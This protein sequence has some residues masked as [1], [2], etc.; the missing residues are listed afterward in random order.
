VPSI[1]TALPLGWMLGAIAWFHAGHATV[2]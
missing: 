1:A 2:S